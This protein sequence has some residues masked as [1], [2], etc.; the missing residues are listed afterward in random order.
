MEI[1]FDGEGGYSVVA[2]GQDATTTLSV[3][4]DHDQVVVDIDA[5]WRNSE[6]SLGVGLGAEEA[7]RVGRCLTALADELDESEE[8]E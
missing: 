4:R 3:E 7:R 5:R 8:E 1:E 6:M 2:T